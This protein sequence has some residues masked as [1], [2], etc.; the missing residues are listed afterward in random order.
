M[1]EFTYYMFNPRFGGGGAL[2]E[3]NPLSLSKK[4]LEFL[5][6]RFFPPPHTLSK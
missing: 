6:K 5:M 4:M 1:L 3:K 2:R